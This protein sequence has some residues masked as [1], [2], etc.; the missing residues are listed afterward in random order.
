MAS[1]SKDDPGRAASVKVL[2]DYNIESSIMKVAGSE[3]LDFVTDEAVQIH[4]G[5]DIAKSTK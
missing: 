5:Y 4:G 1:V 2:E 3:M